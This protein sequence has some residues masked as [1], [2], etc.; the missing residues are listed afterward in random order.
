MEVK[1]RETSGRKNDRRK[2]DDWMIRKVRGRR[3]EKSK[4]K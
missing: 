1:E 3:E 4:N 2:K